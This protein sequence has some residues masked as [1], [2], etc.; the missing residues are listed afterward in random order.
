[1]PRGTL[2]IHCA[3]HIVQFVAPVLTD[4]LKSYPDVTAN[5]TIAE[6]VIDVIAEGF[7][8]SIRLTPLPDS[9]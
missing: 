7:D 9:A 6:H 3:T 4:Y 2:R 8:L 1:M 5:L